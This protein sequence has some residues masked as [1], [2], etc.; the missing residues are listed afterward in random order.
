MNLRLTLVSFSPLL[1]V[2]NLYPDPVQA[3]SFNARCLLQINGTTYMD[4]SCRFSSD[5]DIDSFTDLRLLVTCPNGIDASKTSCYGYEQ[6]VARAGV[7]GYLFRKREVASLCWNEGK[8]RKASP[9]FEGLRRSGAC[10]SNPNAINRDRPST[11]S[12]V[13]FCA[14]AI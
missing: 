9:C 14:W 2:S 3:A 7:F 13:K 12:A 6:K 5:A 4:G 10:W 1:L 11:L 8:M